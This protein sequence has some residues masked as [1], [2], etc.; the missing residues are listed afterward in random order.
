MAEGKHEASMNN[1]KAGPWLLLTE[2]HKGQ[3]QGQVT[4]LCF[5]RLATSFFFQ[6]MHVGLVSGEKEEVKHIT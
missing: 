6:L 5:A 4:V 1:R 3:A 2:A